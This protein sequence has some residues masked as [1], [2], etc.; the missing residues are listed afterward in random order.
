MM[1]TSKA[2][3]NNDTSHSFIIIHVSALS[4]MQQIV[5][6]VCISLLN[7]L[8]QFLHVAELMEDFRQCFE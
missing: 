2:G 6:I 5:Y 4:T 8:H 7:Q 1:K 3:C